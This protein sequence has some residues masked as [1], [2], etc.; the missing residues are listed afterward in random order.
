MKHL[1]NA[2]TDVASLCFFDP[3]ALPEDVDAR[4][5]KEGK[6][7]CEALVR[8]GRLGWIDYDSDGG[9]LLQFYLDEPVPPEAMRHAR[10]PQTIERFHIPSGIVYAA[11]A[12]YLEKNPAQGRLKKYPHMGG[13][14]QLPPGDYAAKSWSIE[15]PE[16]A[17]ERAIDAR[18]GPEGARQRKRGDW[19]GWA[20]M[21]CVLLGGGL[22]L[23]SYFSLKE[24]GSLRAGYG[25]GW[26]VFAVLATFTFKLMRRDTALR[27][28]PE[29]REI[30]QQFPSF[31]VQLQRLA[32]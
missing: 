6:A 32:T 9:Y 31:V 19:T 7:T 24:S 18:L 4:I 12:E 15:W 29:V 25:W 10:N 28:R 3:S 17:I 13:S 8:E 30:E 27:E 1:I 5:Q 16:D 2:G 21:A 14:F 22:A 20:V 26:L 11:G 23:A